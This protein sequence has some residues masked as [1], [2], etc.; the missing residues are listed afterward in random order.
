M[1]FEFLLLLRPF[2]VLFSRPFFF[3]AF[4]RE[5][6]FLHSLCRLLLF[7][8]TR[9]IPSKPSIL[10]SATVL[11]ILEI[12]PDTFETLGI[13]KGIV[14]KTLLSCAVIDN[15]GIGRPS[16]EAREIF[17]SFN[18]DAINAMLEL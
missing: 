9:I 3:L 10:S 15:P 6:D 5:T 16:R 17:R 7:L 13:T 11:S 1:S 8:R 14:K 2:F 18:D 12:A 4:V